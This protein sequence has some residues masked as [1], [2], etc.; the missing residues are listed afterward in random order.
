MRKKLIG[1]LLCILMMLAF[2]SCK[3]EEE[4]VP[5][6]GSQACDIADD[7]CGDDSTSSTLAFKEAY[8][9]LN[10]TTNASGKENRTISI[11]EDH[12]FEETEP[13]KVI[14]MIENKETFYLYVG[15]EMCPWCRSVIEKAIEV[16]KKAGIKKIYY[17]QIWDDEHNEILRN[18]YALEEGELVEKVETRPEY[19]KLLAY[20]DEVLSDYTLKDEDGNVVEVGQKR[21]YA[22]NFFYVENG[23]VNRF[24]TGTSEKQEDARQEL[25]DDIIADEIDMFEEFFGAER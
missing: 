7:E 4:K 20:F 5:D 19:E 25:S 1:L 22:P 13:S 17:L 12:P 18:Q 8:E 2:S 11:P 16:A 9:S 21:I 10:G 23:K 24:T 6:S 14:Q 15:D 3:K